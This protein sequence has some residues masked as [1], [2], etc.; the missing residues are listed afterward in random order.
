MAERGKFIACDC[1]FVGTSEIYGPGANLHRTPYSGR[2]F[3]YYSE[4][5]IFSYYCGIAQTQG[6]QKYGLTGSI[7]HFAGNDQETG[8]QDMHNFMTEQ[9]MRQDPLKA[10]EGAYRAEGGALSSMM[11]YT[12]FGMQSD[13]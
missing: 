8:R 4:D 11:S 12:S 5:G 1:A 10:F 2:N 6:M 7:K 13:F 9:K 3:E